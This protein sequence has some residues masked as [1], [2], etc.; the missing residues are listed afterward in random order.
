M[1]D[2]QRENVHRSSFIV[3]RL[4]FRAV[5]R[6]LPHRHIAVEGPIGVGKTS[7]TNL[8]AKR[9]RGT[10][11]LEDADN[12]FLD[13]FYKDKRSAAFRCE[14]FFL[15]SRF[16]QQRVIAQGDLFTQLIIADY[17]FPKSKIF[18]HLTLDDSELMI[19][20]RLYDLLVDT[21][22]KPGLVI[23]LQANI[24]TLLKR[25]KK[26][27]RGYEKAISPQYLQELSEAY[28]HYF[29]RYDETPLLV[30][31]TNDI[32]FVNTPEHFDQLEEQIRNAQK[33]TQY[34]VPLGS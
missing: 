19:Y 21:V 26:R 28:S 18:A 29:Y 3:H 27:G 14:L 32:D 7:L 11:I 31:N 2:E 12:P 24:D 4:S 8:L 30:V 5:T 25:I 16:D 10:K 15:L 33:G 9:F 20:N 22:P 6:P 17:T 13:D 1:N 23:Y 34:Y